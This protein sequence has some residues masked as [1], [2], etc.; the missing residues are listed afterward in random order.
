MKVRIK[1]KDNSKISLITLLIVSCVALSIGYSALSTTLKIN[2]VAN[3]D[4][5]SFKIEFQNLSEASLTGNAVK[6]TDPVISEDKTEL[7]SYNVNFLDPGDSISYTFQIANNGTINAK[8]SEIVKDTISCEGYGNGEQATKDAN[9]VCANLEYTLKYI[10]EEEHFDDSGSSK[11]YSNDIEVNDVLNAGDVKDMILTLKYKSPVD[12]VTIEEPED[13]VSISGLGISLTYSQVKTPTIGSNTPVVPDEPINTVS[14]A[15]DSWDTIAKAVKAGKTENYKVGDTKEV[16]LGTYGKHNVRIANM[17]TPSECNQNGFSQSACGF[18]VEFTDI[19]TTHNMNPSGEYNG[20][21]YNSG[22]NKDGWP[23]SQM[24]TFIDNDIYNSLPQD[25]KSVIITTETVSGH[26]KEDTNNFTSSDKLYLLSTAEIWVQDTSNT[27]DYDAARDKTRQLDYYK[28]NGVTTS[29]YAGAIKNNNSGSATSWWLRSANSNT[30][31]GFYAVAINGNW[32]GSITTVARNT[33]G[34][35]PAFRL[36]GPVEESINTVSFAE[37]SWDTIAKAVKAGNTS[38]YHVGDTKEVDL[39]TYGKH[40]VRIANMN[41][42]NEC[43]QEGFSQSACGFVVEFIDVI[44]THVMNPS[45]DYKGTT[46]NSGWNK[47]GWPKSQMK[48]F[49]DNDIYNSLPQELKSV[50]ITT[51]T[52]SGHG[53]EDTNNFT[54]IDKLYL[55]STAEVWAQGTS[56]T[57]D[58]DTARDKTRR[59]DYYNEKGVTTN[60]YDAAIKNNSSGTATAWWWLRSARSNIYCNFYYVGGSGDWGNHGAGTTGG[61]SP[62]FRIG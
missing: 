6:I 30:N 14:F 36:E 13:D 5:M 48:T 2:G 7:K 15:E 23:K 16:D 51:E 9:N 44:T 10:N 38:N 20:T 55:L 40:K 52:V 33:Y 12:G 4:G 32:S 56:N 34:V 22:W 37:D 59:L 27:I 3:V 1:N 35:S 45:G 54:S 43:K 58:S 61:V 8:L 19:I 21:T 57:I 62:A 26:G 28:S 60:S 11:T 17:S 47:D 53:S 24:K 46:Y 39:G 42:P 41:T 18:V 29:S 31:T 50:I 49:I 25:L